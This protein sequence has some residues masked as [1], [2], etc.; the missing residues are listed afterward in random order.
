[1]VVVSDDVFNVERT[2]DPAAMVKLVFDISKKI[3]PTLCTLILAVVDK[4]A[5]TVIVSVPSFG[6]ELRIVRG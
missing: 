3:F 1:M 6:V 5:G 2:V 4:Y